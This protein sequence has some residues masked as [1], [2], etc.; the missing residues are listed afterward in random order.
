MT[1]KYFLIISVDS[2]TNQYIQILAVVWMC[3]LKCIE[4]CIAFMSWLFS[5]H[6]SEN[7]I[8]YQIVQFWKFSVWEAFSCL[9]FHFKLCRII[10]NHKHAGL[11][12][13]NPIENTNARFSRIGL[14][15]ND[16]CMKKKVKKGG[17]GTWFRLVSFSKCRYKG[18]TNE[19]TGENIDWKK[20]PRNVCCLC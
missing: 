11:I 13:E 19:L 10:Q 17:S 2:L 8:Q 20:W 9:H 4:S 7:L 1:L 14:C 6:P 15:R 18:I 5:L 3:N 12:Q 16:L